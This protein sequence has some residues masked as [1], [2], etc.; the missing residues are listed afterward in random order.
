MQIKCLVCASQAQQGLLLSHLA[1]DKMQAIQY[2]CHK[3]GVHNDRKLHHM[4][5]N[6][7]E[8]NFKHLQY[9]TF[10]ISRIVNDIFFM[11]SILVLFY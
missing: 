10:V 9:R 4:I 8:N 5:R 11:C 1:L 2:M 7:L 3:V 6:K